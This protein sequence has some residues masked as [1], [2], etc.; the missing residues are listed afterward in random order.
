MYFNLKEWKWPLFLDAQN[1][2]NK[3]FKNIANFYLKIF[4]YLIKTFRRFY[5]L[6]IDLKI[7]YLIMTYRTHNAICDSLLFPDSFNK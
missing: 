5:L 4:E 7:K 6:L 1:A 3:Y 2:E